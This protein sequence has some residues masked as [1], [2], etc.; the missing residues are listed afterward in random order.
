MPT[1]AEFP[2]VDRRGSRSV[3]RLTHPLGQPPH[4]QHA[5]A[6]S[7]PDLD[8]GGGAGGI[9]AAG[10][11]QEHAGHTTGPPSRGERARSRVCR[12]VAGVSP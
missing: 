1:Q 11:K 8:A 10:G 5:G 3:C 12:V 2:E 7:I 6:G 4:A 9:P